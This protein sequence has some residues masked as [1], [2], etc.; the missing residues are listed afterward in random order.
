MSVV[1]AIKHK[2]KCWLACDR[3]IT[4]GDSK[5]FLETHDKIFEVPGRE[6]C[7]LG[8]VGMLRGINLL[9]TNNCYIDELAY[10]KDEIDYTY[11]VNHFPLVVQHLFAENGM[12]SKDELDDSFTLK[13]DF[14][15]ITPNDHMFEVAWDGSVI[16]KTE[17]A[18]IGSG[19][20]YAL[21]ALIAADLDE[22]ATDEEVKDCLINALAA[23]NFNL[24]C[25][26]GGV[27]MNNKD[28]SYYVF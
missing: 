4:N 21:G 25:G 23:A 19:K 10:L 7:L 8:H 20:E 24:G 12:I 1:I 11:V 14:L 2:D 17:F 27:I 22:E 18:A 9:E 3:Q 5:A 16:E 13:G 15:L 6:G 28:D 26:G